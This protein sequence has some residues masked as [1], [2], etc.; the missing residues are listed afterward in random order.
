M[1][2]KNRACQPACDIEPSPGGRPTRLTTT[3]QDRFIAAIKAGNFRE[4]AARL[5]GISPATMY[6]W[7]SAD[8][9]PYLSFRSAVEAAEAELEASVLKTVTD[10]IPDDPRLALS[11]LAKRFPRRWG[12]S[13]ESPLL[14][15]EPATSGPPRQLNVLVVDPAQLQA[16]AQRHLQAHRQQSTDGQR[17]EVVGMNAPVGDEEAPA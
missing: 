15:H 14:A 7:L 13:A 1:N 4:T 6:R 11:F 2:K 10:R 12:S 16:A 8:Q 5:A 9:E 17:P 3:V